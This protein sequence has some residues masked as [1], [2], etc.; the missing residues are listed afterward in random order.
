MVVCPECGTKISKAAASCPYCGYRSSVDNLPMKFEN[1]LAKIK[2]DEGVFSHEF[3]DI[4][5][6]SNSQDKQLSKIFCD[7][8]NLERVAPPLFEAVKAMIPKTV[9]IAELLPKA[10]E[11]LDQGV[12]QF[13]LDKNGEI[14]PSVYDTVTNKIGAQVR[15]KDLKLS[16]EMGPAIANLQTQV[17][18]A[19]IIGEIHDVQQGIANLH[20]EI[21]GDRLAL[22]D[23]VWEQLRQA[24]YITDSRLRTD[25][26]LAILGRTTD[27]KH[28]LI[29]AFERDKA[30]LDSKYD[31]NLFFD[32]DAQKHSCEHCSD[33]FVNLMMVTK[34]VQ[35]EATAYC[36]LDEQDA[37][38]YCLSEFRT[39]INRNNLDEHDTLLELNSFSKKDNAK[40][41]KQFSKVGKSIGQLLR[42]KD[43]IM[44]EAEKE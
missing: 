25:K 40:V 29:R 39:F 32:L 4:M 7:A 36:V 2:W 21:Q 35:V 9:K 37:A 15:L 12:L 24:S 8:Q 31:K 3:Y 27:V 30:Y 34:M 16:P 1:K 5:P 28:Q 44:I 20:Y 22:A 13:K 17:V 43:A 42:P 19:Q 33:L 10:Q 11:L 14:L 41:I 38:M 26:V 18:M 6:I 23:S